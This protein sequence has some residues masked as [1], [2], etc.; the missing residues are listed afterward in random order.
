MSIKGHNVNYPKPV[1]NLNAIPQFNLFNGMTLF[2][3]GVCPYAHRTWIALLEHGAPLTHLV[4][5]CH[6]GLG[7]SMQPW[8]KTHINPK[9]TV[10]SLLLHNSPVVKAKQPHE[11]R[12][13]ND[14]FLMLESLDICKFFDKF[15]HAPDNADLF[16]D[17]IFRKNGGKQ[18]LIPAF[19]EATMKLSEEIIVFADEVVFPEM[20]EMLGSPKE[21]MGKKA[22][23][24]KALLKDLE[25]K[26][27]KPALERSEK[28][29][30]FLGAEPSL[31]DIALV[32]FLD[33]FSHTLPY[34]CKGEMDDIFM[35]MPH[36]RQMYVG[37]T[38]RNSFRMTAMPGDYY[39]RKYWG[40]THL[41]QQS[42]SASSADGE[43]EWK[44]MEK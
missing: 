35:R 21:K 15:V 11:L 18:T 20:Y 26:F 32:P 24:L 8:Y 2:V 38:K 41:G 34:Y 6:P 19:D 4:N 3:H 31:V 7:N 23:L 42:G 22:V 12:V 36:I 5:V 37:F 33:R 14:G 40:Y 39:I 13:P 29:P 30:F 1:R 16:P 27:A 10:P 28:A 25:I 17:D 43:D 9:E 44:E